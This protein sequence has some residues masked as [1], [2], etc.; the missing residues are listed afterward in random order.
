[1]M[2][3]ENIIRIAYLGP[4]A[5]FGE[6]AN[7]FFIKKYNLEKAYPTPMPSVRQIVEY[8][9]TNPGTLG[10]VPVENSVIGTVRETLDTLMK[11]ENTQINILAGNRYTNPILSGIKNYGVLQYNR[12]Y[13][14]ST[15][16]G[17]MSRI[18]RKR[19]PEKSQ[20]Y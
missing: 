19:T 10:V 20:Y 6:M 1:M 11:P 4:E 12:D 2:N 16:N 13:C 5:S 15:G 18:H 17:T 7:D 3:F 14:K 9:Q 8:V